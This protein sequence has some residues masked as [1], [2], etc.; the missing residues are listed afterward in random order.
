METNIIVKEN[1][2]NIAEFSIIQRIY[3]IRGYKVMLDYDL[4]AK[5]GVETKRLKE[6]VRRNINRFLGDDF[7]FE[8]TKEEWESLRSQI[9][10]SKRGG[11]RYMPFA[12]T[13]LGV[14]MLSSVLNSEE[15]IETNRKIMRAFVA[16]QQYAVTYAELK[17]ELDMYI[18]KTDRKIGDICEVLEELII[19]KEKPQEPRNPIGFKQKS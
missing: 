14:A 2:K 10:T 4:A 11:T 13:Q 18:S 8:L 3:E 1:R 9:A 7:M 16:I 17:H 19:E 15:A 5:Y 6:A 12:F